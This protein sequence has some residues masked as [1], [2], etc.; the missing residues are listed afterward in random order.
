MFN[1]VQS[2]KTKPTE[3]IV[4]MRRSKPEPVGRERLKH[5]DVETKKAADSVSDF[6]ARVRRLEQIITDAAAAHAALQQAIAADVNQYAITWGSKNLRNAARVS[7]IP[8]IRSIITREFR[9]GYQARKARSG[10]PSS[11]RV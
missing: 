5:L 1:R 4:S 3:K 11:S 2:P 9:P 7:Y 8:R 10:T 6:E